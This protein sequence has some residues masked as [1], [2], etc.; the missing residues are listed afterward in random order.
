MVRAAMPLLG[1]AGLVLLLSGLLS[2]AL[3]REFD[4]WTAVHLTGG[5]VLVVLAVGTNLAGVR[6]TVQSRSTRE[7]A[8]AVLA[9]VLFAALLVTI[10]VLAARSP[11]RYDATANRIHTLS[12]QA[13]SVVRSLRE[14]V[15]VLVFLSAGA[16][17][18]EEIEPLLQR[19][20][21]AGTN[22]RW[23]FVDPVQEPE[24]ARQ[25]GVSRE[26]VVVA[27]T[28]GSTAQ[29]SGD[30]QGGV[31]EGMLVN[32]LVKVKRPDRPVVYVL[33]GHGE[34]AL[35][36]LRG[37]EGLGALAASL[38]DENM[39]V[40][41]LL[42]SAKPAVPPDADVVVLAAARRPLF[43]HEVEQL[44]A[45]LASGG[46]A[47]V[48]LDPGVEPGLDPV[49]AAHGIEVGN[50]MVVDQE[51][52]P[53]F[54]ARL[55]VDPI[56]ETF[57]EHAITR[58]FRD[59][60]VLLQAR[61]VDWGGPPSAGS[62]TGQ[63][64]AETRE[65][66]WAE[67]GWQ[68]MLETREVGRDADDE[69]GPVPVAAVAESGRARLVVV[70]DSDLARNAN[71][72]AYGNREFLLNAVSWLAGSEELI[73]ERPRG[74]RPSRLDMTTAD[75]RTLFRLGVLLLPEAIL[76]VGLAIWWRRRSL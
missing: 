62:V 44:R 4:L 50:D 73:A 75:F 14:P 10:N 21:A 24:L 43:P 69:E 60:I 11:W 58:S 55:G 45:F 20:A 70:G 65:A 64:L 35:D 72:G 61:S 52:I 9:A 36:D 5:A 31:T 39:D 18:R 28:R 29:T 27:R 63:V 56:V 19:L 54:G 76:I 1:L 13:V 33:T 48:L 23:R 2:Y 67:R 51:E 59:R 42:L 49:L 26:G 46:R 3:T 41:P 38:R 68:R 74:L 57:P 30:E 7:R 12:D 71:L 8:Q 47:L 15:E 32:L 53:F 17:E 37:P 66:S 22:L 6:R 25:T 16:Q 34:P 40:R